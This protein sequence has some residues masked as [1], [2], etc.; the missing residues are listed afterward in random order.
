[1]VLYWFLWLVLRAWYRLVVRVRLEG[2]NQVPRGE[3][4]VV[5]SNHISWQDPML[6]GAVMPRQLFFM[7]KAEAF[8][9][10]LGG[11]ILRTVGAFPVRRHTA[12]RGAIR[13]ALDLLK[14]RR[15]VVVFPEGT[16]SRD[17]RLGI[18]EPGAALLAVWSGAL[19][20]PVAI[21]GRYRR[22]ALRVA[23]GTPFRVRSGPGA[24]RPSTS[25]LQRIAQEQI[26]GAVGSLADQSSGARG[27]VTGPA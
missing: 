16:R 8:A 26:M 21:S 24:R 10:P 23:V 22:G 2:L 4:F 1:M 18:A 14:S 20:L 25:E 3:G 12:D 7:T 27:V 11:L 15:P 13:R 19:V 17:G 6:L 5:C 9:S